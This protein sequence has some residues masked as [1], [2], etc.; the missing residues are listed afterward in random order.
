[1]INEN[2]KPFILRKRNTD[3][4]LLMVHGFTAS[5]SE[6]LPIAHIISNSM[7]WD[8][9]GPLLPGHG[10]T[11]QALNK[12]SWSNWYAALENSM[13][14][15]RPNYD[16]IY[17]VGL[18]MGALLVLK[19]G[20]Q[21]LGIKGI[22]SINAPIFTKSM[23]LDWGIIEVLKYFIPLW[24]KKKSDLEDYLS[25]QGRFAYS[26]YPLVAMSSMNE[27]R[28][29]AKKQVRNIKSPVLIVQSQLDENVSL[30][31]AI[32]LARELGQAQDDIIMLPRST[33]IAT[34][35]REKEDLAQ[36]IIDF[37]KNINN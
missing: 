29:Q 23:L 10:E 8:V 5:P 7:G 28:K 26:F 20:T 1:M 37:I 15:M 30:K 6:L 27:L 18:S 11:P 24:P 14:E 31:S 4:A 9:Y 32:F 17:L 21:E 36:A 12:M 2:A 13:R 22:V 3:T 25:K 33:H 34:M 16:K 35:D 19:M